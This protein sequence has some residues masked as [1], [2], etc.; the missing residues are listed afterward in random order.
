MHDKIFICAI[1]RACLYGVLTQV[2]TPVLTMQHGMP[3]T[4]Y[5][6]TSSLT[7]SH[8]CCRCFS[9]IITVRKTILFDIAAEG[10]L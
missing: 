3:H 7:S 9:A 10:L 4:E 5:N 1:V 2:L 8:P 6:F